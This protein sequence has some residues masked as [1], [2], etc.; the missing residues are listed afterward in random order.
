GWTWYTGSAGWMYRVWIEGVL[1]FAPR[2]DKLFINPNIPSDWKEYKINWRYKSSFYQVQILNPDGKESGVARISVDGEVQK[3][4]FV[5]LVDDG[6]T[7]QV[8]VVLE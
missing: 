7:H 6:K 8:E 5:A 4:D 3:T 1:G 2:A